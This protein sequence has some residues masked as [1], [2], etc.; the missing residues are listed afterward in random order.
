MVSDADYET[1]IIDKI[2]Q[3]KD[4]P[5]IVFFKGVNELN[6]FSQSALF[7]PFLKRTY[8]LTE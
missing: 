4:R 8:S 1:N 7:E 3:V 5:V 6:E 2:V